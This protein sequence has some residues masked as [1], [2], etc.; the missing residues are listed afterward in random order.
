MSAFDVPSTSRPNP[1]RNFQ[2]EYEKLLRKVN[3][4]NHGEF[5]QTVD[6]LLKEAKVA[7]DE[8]RM[9]ASA[10]A[11]QRCRRGGKTFML[12]AI[13]SM[14]VVDPRFHKGTRVLFIS[15]NSESPYNPQEDA[16]TA[17]L[18]RIAWELIGRKQTFI[19]FKDKYND[20]GEVDEWLTS[21]GNHVILIIDELNMIQFT[22]ARYF[23]IS[24]LI[25]SCKR[26]VAL[27]CTRLISVEQP[28]SYVAVVLV[29][30]I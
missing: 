21:Q 5:Q 17:I 15:M 30:M 28:I 24:F 18:S 6:A 3:P 29:E 1:D 11:I 7:D 13:A 12:H 23:D 10:L 2:A 20:F 16:Y 25:Y 14:V 27:F 22:A 4:V 26:M 9:R 19:R 8:G